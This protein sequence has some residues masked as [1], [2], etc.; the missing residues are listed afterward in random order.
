MKDFTR[1]QL[2]LTILLNALPHDFGHPVTSFYGINR[3]ELQLSL[4]LITSRPPG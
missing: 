2:I 1:L 3:I 4:P